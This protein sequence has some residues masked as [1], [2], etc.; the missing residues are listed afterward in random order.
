[1]IRPCL[2]ALVPVACLAVALLPAALVAHPLGNVSTNHWAGV[3]VAPEAVT[4][5]YVLDL[6]ELPAFRERPRLDSDG[7]GRI[8]SSEEAIWAA[9]TADAIAADL[10]LTLDG[11][12]LALVRETAAAQ[13][14]PGAAGLDTLRL[15]A[16]FR[17]TLPA[18]RGA[19]VF[20]D[21]HLPE[22]PGWREIV[23]RGEGMTLTAATVPAT[24]ASDRLR[25]YPEDAP[26]PLRVREARADVAPGTHGGLAAATAPAPAPRPS[27]LAS[28]LG[29]LV[30]NP[31]P[32]APG[33]VAGALLL[34]VLL[35][36]CHA[37][38][39]GHGKTIV[40]TY[41]VGARGT[42]RHALLLGTTVT[43]TH[44]A[45]IFA[46]GALTLAASAWLVPERLLPWMSLASGLL[47]VAVGGGLVRTRLAG[48]DRAH[49][50]HHAHGHSH[51]QG[52]AHSHPPPTGTRSAPR[53]LI[54]LGVSGGLAPCPSALVVMLGAIAAGRPGFG[55]ALTTAFSLGLAGVLT[56][57]G[58]TLVWARD[59]F[60]RLPLEGRLARALPVASA[61]VVSLAGLALVAGA[62]ME[63]AA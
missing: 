52:H 59:L 11:H 18:R 40:G 7:D 63:L 28:R 55:L 50:H 57:V 15:D 6:A 3:V 1:M 34:A 38:S 43:A 45:G 62:I 47:V 13:R 26:A 31:A 29:A 60:E 39:P 61:A 14:P 32:L 25:R 20:R 49:H 16:T 4:I 8:T 37:L 19:L 51:D 36:A 53:S 24:D 2:S 5:A 17:A 58:L 10:V 33:T 56:G 9:A 12:R 21:D 27:D 48:Y 46:L 30:T 41:L 54:A 42:A 23:L 44:T 35:G 22:R